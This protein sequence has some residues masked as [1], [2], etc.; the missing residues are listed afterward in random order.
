MYRNKEN[1][2]SRVS[3]TSKTSLPDFGG[4]N[5]E[6]YMYSKFIKQGN[7]VYPPKTMGK[8]RKIYGSRH[9]KKEINPNAART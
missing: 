6:E 4:E 2:L 7:F 1:N 3:R 5:L 8:G 9:G